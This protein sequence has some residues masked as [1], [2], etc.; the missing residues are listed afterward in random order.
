MNCIFQKRMW[1]AGASLLAIVLGSGDA[2]AAVFETPGSNQYLIPV[3]GYYDVTVA[4]AQGGS[5][6][7]SGA[8]GGAGAVV[9]GELFFDSGATLQI[10]VGGAGGSGLRGDGYG[11]GGGGGSFIFGSGL[12]FA[13]AGGSG[14]PFSAGKRQSGNRIWRLSGR[15]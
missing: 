4:G 9:G 6:G 7:G 11:G 14:A 13:A 3:T 12:L 2:N 15:S 10:F 5:G 8:P 1:L